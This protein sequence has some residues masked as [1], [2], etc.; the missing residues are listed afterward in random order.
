METKPAR[1]LRMPH[2]EAPGRELDLDEAQ[3]VQRDLSFIG[4]GTVSMDNPQ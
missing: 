4:S 1:Q 2:M 3:A